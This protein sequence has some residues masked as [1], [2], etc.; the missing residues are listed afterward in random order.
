M[1][2]VIYLINTSQVGVYVES[3][4]LLH[5]PMDG[6]EVG[7]LDIYVNDVKTVRLYNNTDFYYA[8]VVEVIDTK[9][10]PLACTA[11]DLM[12]STIGTIDIFSTAGRYSLRIICDNC[13]KEIFRNVMLEEQG[14]VPI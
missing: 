2:K 9:F 10:L 13:P 8:W 7:T 11:L 6:T 4:G 5:H 14:Y 12:F 1:S 3:G